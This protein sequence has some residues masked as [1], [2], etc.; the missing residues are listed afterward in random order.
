MLRALL[1][2]TLKISVWVWCMWSRS[3]WMRHCFLAAGSRLPGKQ[4]RH[5]HNGIQFLLQRTSSLSRQDKQWL[6]IGK[7]HRSDPRLNSSSVAL[8][9]RHESEFK[10]KVELYPALGWTPSFHSL[11]ISPGADFSHDMQFFPYLDCIFFYAPYNPCLS[12]MLKRIARQRQQ[13]GF[14]NMMNAFA[15]LVF[16]VKTPCLKDL[17]F[18][19]ML[20]TWHWNSHIFQVAQVIHLKTNSLTITCHQCQKVYP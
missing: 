12:L 17:D 19:K 9:V 10:S 15:Y 18:P 6:G 2:A 5:T 4:Y 14:P 13:P 20:N 16:W 11:Q 7:W 3:R 1:C 8:G